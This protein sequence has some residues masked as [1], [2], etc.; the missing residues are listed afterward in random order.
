MARGLQAARWISRFMMAALVAGSL[1]LTLGSGWRIAQNPLLRPVIERTGAEFAAATDRMIAREATAERMDA[2]IAARLVEDPRN[3]VA[4]QAL[5]G[6]AAERGLT[7]RTRAA[8][9]AAR[10][11]DTS[12]AARAT[13]CAVCIWDAA[14]CTL[15][16]ALLCQAPVALTPVSDIAGIARAGVA[17]ATGAEVDRIDLALSIVGLGATA[18]VVASGGTSGVVKA[19]ASMAKLARKMG[20]LSPRLTAMATDAVRS[21]VDW[22]ALPA[23]R[24][25][26][27]LA[28]AIRM[29]AFTPLL[30]TATD[31]GKVR[32]AVGTSQALHLL[33]HVEDAAD[34]RRLARA[35]EALGPR[36]VG[37]M[38]VLGKARL[39]RAGVRLTDVALALL[40]GIASLAAAVAR[41]IGN[42]AG[43]V[44]RRAL[45]G[46][47]PA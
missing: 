41:M 47:R 2:L 23:V 31:L 22:A 36:T 35:S 10:A 37:R 9:D 6:I 8:F 44:F 30:A 46:R 4:L 18:L 20:L 5:D 12:L 17:H 39:F 40:S 34:A 45:G 33:R 28:R 19:G 3:W 21:G 25:P 14:Q 11:E 43:H 16:T 32:D 42:A 24:S 1:V 13:D 26:D 38:E 29:D 27:D 7:L 15:S